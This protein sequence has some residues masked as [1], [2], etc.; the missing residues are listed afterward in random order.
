[1]CWNVRGINAR[2]KWNAIRDK[3]V[4]SSYD[5]VCLQENKKKVFDINFLKNVCPPSFDKVGISSLYGCFWWDA[6]S[7][8]E[9]SV[10][11]P[12]YFQ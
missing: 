2:T 5:V 10:Q 12:A 3:V 11:R 8:E 6:N 1:M 4:D 7:L 9:L